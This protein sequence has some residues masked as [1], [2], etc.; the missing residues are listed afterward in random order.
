MAGTTNLMQAS[1]PPLAAKMLGGEITTGVSAAGSTAADAT[2]VAAG[3]VVLSTVGSGAGVILPSA[4][5]S[6]P[7]VVVNG[8]ANTVAVYPATG[9]KINNGTAS[10]SVNVTNAKNG[11]FIPFGNQWGFVLGA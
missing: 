11:I 2:P 10:A 7:T 3:L 4:T 9:E 6:G 8:G 5:I 1:I